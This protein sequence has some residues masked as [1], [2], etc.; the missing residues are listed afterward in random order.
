MN[1]NIT[2]VLIAD[3]GGTN[4]RLSLVLIEKTNS[5]YKITEIDKKTYTTFAHKTLKSI[6]SNYISS[7]KSTEHF[8]V[9]AVLGLPGAIINNKVV[10]SHALSH[11]NG[12]TGEE[13]AKSIGIRH[14]L[15]LNDFNVNGYSNHLS[16]TQTYN[17]Y[18]YFIQ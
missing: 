15:Y 14:V 7:F 10:L 5:D 16:F 4:A 13:M 6:L 17:V 2:P 8:P 12:T 18:E 1:S 9:F 3:I 11:L